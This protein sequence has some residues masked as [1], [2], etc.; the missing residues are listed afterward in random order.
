MPG[1]MPHACLKPPLLPPSAAMAG[2]AAASAIYQF[3]FIRSQILQE[4][5]LYLLHSWR[6]AEAT[7]GLMPTLETA[8]VPSIIICWRLICLPSHA[9]RRRFEAHFKRLMLDGPARLMRRLA[10]PD[11][12]EASRAFMT[13]LQRVYHVASR[14]SR[15]S[16]ESLPV[17]LPLATIRRHD[18]QYAIIAP[19]SFIL[20]HATAGGCWQEKQL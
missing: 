5:H 20:M 8:R 7:R 17:Y 11:R 1:T 10:A 19:P 2:R 13:A 15:P 18:E 6:A 16:S 4:S 9:P 3:T 14:K 12:G